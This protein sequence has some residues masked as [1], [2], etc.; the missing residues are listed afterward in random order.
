MQIHYRE[1]Q[2]SLTRVILDTGSTGC[3]FAI[4]KLEPIDLLP[5]PNDPIHQIKGVGGTEFVFSKHVD[6]LIAGE[7]AVNNFEIEVGAMNYGFEID[8]ILGLDFLLQ[9]KAIINLS[10]LSLYHAG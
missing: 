6:R 1:K 4:D 9:T 8:G 7:L 5:A 3:I 10:Q 2:I